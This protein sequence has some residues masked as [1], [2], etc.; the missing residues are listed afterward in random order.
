MEPG[1]E[2]PFG[3][4]SGALLP[5]QVPRTWS[6]IT[7]QETSETKVLAWT[8]LEGEEVGSRWPWLGSGARA[9]ISLDL[10]SL[11]DETLLAGSFW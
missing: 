11:Q 3:P 6:A 7:R 8:S 1:S 2:A 10:P 5:P 4:R 9:H